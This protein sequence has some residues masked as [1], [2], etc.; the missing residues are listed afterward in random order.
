MSAVNT[1]LTTQATMSKYS[2]VRIPKGSDICHIQE[3]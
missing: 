2:T 3:F 1:V